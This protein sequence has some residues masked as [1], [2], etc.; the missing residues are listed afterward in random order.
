MSH[1]LEHYLTPADG[2]ECGHPEI[3]ALARSLALGSKDEAEAAGRLFNYVRDTVRYNPYVPFHRIEDYLALTVL[4]RG[5]GY[6]VQKAA[7]LCALARA[8]GIPCR[9]GFADIV[10]HQLPVGL[11]EMLGSDVMYHHSFVEWWL[12]GAWRKA[13]PSF[14]TRLTTERGW[15]LVEF[16]PEGDCLLPETDAAGAP[17]ISYLRYLG[18]SRGV[19]LDEI[20][21]SWRAAYGQERVEDWIAQVRQ[22][23]VWGQE[24]GQ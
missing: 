14:D 2:I 19:P 7:L 16:D 12:R 1:D 17:H 11:Y 24:A 21:D 23:G 10:N 3:L 13:T 9:L 18:H 20:L 22:G 6:C 4:A 8:L 5:K 15:R